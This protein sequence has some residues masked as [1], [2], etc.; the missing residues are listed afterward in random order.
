MTLN[1]ALRA[2]ATRAANWWDTPPDTASCPTIWG[3]F[4]SVSSPARFAWERVPF[5][6]EMP[7]DGRGVRVDVQALDADGKVLPLLRFNVSGPAD[8]GS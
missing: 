8:A 4:E 5:A 2:R 3:V 1:C 6:L 7:A